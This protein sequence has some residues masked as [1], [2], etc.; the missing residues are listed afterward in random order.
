MVLGMTCTL[1]GHTLALHYLVGSRAEC[2]LLV[3]PL[4]PV[5]AASHTAW[6]QVNRD[7]PHYVCLICASRGRWQ[8]PV[9]S[10]SCPGHRPTSPT[11]TADDVADMRR[12]LERYTYATVG[13]QA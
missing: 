5:L 12:S 8:L 2:D 1:C 7:H 10:W 13:A 4:R 11:F 3:S 9:E 6:H